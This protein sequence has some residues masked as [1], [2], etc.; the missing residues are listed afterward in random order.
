M[1]EEPG[2]Q[3]VTLEEAV[4]WCAEHEAEINFVENRVYVYIDCDVDIEP[5]SESDTLIGAVEQARK[6]LK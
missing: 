4:Q 2:G 1:A 5:L 6:A 3:R